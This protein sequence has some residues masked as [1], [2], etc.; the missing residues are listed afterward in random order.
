MLLSKNNQKMAVRA[1]SKL[2]LA[3]PNKTYTS[4]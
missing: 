2:L 1:M 4:N 3:E